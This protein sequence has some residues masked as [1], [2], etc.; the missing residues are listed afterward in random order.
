M[1]RAHVI[2]SI[3][4][5]ASDLTAI[6]RRVRPEMREVVRESIITGNKLAKTYARR[7]NGPR[8]HA[9]KY[10]GL[11]TAEMRGGLGLFGNTISG[12][13]GPAHR[14]QGMLAGILEDGQGAN[15]P[16]NNMR[17]SADLAGPLLAYKVGKRVDGWFW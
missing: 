8:S 7:A 3:G 16:Q 14:G 5:L 4:D 13:Y 17:R 9:R 2:H 15:A 11:F 1:T 10:P 12:E 6:S